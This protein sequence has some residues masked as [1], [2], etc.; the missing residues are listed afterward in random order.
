MSNDPRFLPD[1]ATITAELHRL[2]QAQPADKPIVMLVAFWGAGAEHVIMPDRHYRL[3]CN[4]SS[5]G[6]NPDVIRILMARDGVEMRQLPDL[7]AKLVLTESGALVSS[8][9][10]SANGLLLDSG[11]RGWLE[12][13]VL[14]PAS[15]DAYARAR[16]RTQALWGSAGSV[17]Q[18]LLEQAEQR[19]TD[20]LPER[21]EGQPL[22]GDPFVKPELTFDLLFG[23]PEKGNPHNALPAASARLD[24]IYGQCLGQ[25]MLKP[26][27]YFVPRY[28][29]CLLWTHKGHSVAW[30]DGTFRQ[31]ADVVATWRRYRVRVKDD[32]V[33]KYLSYLARSHMAP[34]PIRR[35]SGSFLKHGWDQAIE[36]ASG[37]N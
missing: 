33:R 27:D 16:E 5:G 36:D 26:R 25:L 1:R 18:R 14:L 3:V 4:L 32:A 35:S 2:T 7:H 29:A 34:E 19:F 23:P 17:T 22:G 11:Q 28:V 10:L 31:P 8:A 21:P 13:G 24:A 15:S 20:S 12:A 30:R 6:T 37:R 9:N